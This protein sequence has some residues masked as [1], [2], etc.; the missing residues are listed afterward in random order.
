MV[1]PARI[2]ITGASGFVGQHLTAALRRAC[3]DA[4][5]FTD[6]FDVRDPDAVRAAVRAASPDAC[7]HLAGIASPVQARSEPD[8]AW[9]VN[10]MGTVHLAR[11][12]LA[13]VPGC[14]FLFVSTSEVYGASFRPGTPVDETA[15]LAPMNTYAATKAA[16]DL[17]VGAM[18]NDG[19]RAIRVRPFNH[20]GPGQTDAYVVPAFARQ[21]AQI[22]AGLRAASMRVGGLDSERDF[23]D[24]RDICSAYVAC[25][26]ATDAVLPPGTILNLAS[27]VPRR[28]G[29]V[30]ADLC[31]IAGLTPAIVSDAGL[32]RPTDIP[33]ARGDSTMARRLLGWAPTI[34]WEQTLS[35]VLADWRGRLP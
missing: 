15:P 27:G 34:A 10:L 24:V 21:L 16:A 33:R 35:D 3:P 9:Q 5:L 8:M 30:L 32:L 6:F 29:D 20:T 1:N 26:T 23:V 2:L 28:I 11:A 12:L 7:V 25:L 14:R 4:A 19:L 31:R 18:V 17:A 13:D 22:G